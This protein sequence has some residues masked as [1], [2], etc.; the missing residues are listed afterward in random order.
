MIR[1][2]KNPIIKPEDIEPSDPGFKVVGVFNCGVV[3]FEDEVLLLMRV[4]EEPI[5]N[6][7]KKLL[8]SW[9]DVNT[10]KFVV[11]KFNKADPSIDISDPRIVKSPDRYFLTSVSHF[12]IARSKNGIDFE[13][14]QNPAMFSENIYERFGIEDPRT[15]QIAGKYYIS[16][17]AISDIDGNYQ[18]RT[19]YEL[20]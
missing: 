11:K 3:R 6:N 19:V 4:A 16:Y 5:N 17:S 10:R 18:V 20:F 12:R 7:I 15:T 9:F 2:E 8:V 1:S 13:I 14:D